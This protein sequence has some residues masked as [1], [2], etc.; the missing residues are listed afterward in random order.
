MADIFSKHD[1]K[2]L[3]SKRDIYM[4]GDSNM[5]AFYKDLICLVNKGTLIDDAKLRQKMEQSHMQDKLVRGSAITAGRDYVEEREYSRNNIYVKYHFITRCW[6]SSLENFVKKCADNVIR[7]DVVIVNSCL[8]DITRWGPRGV[9]QYRDNIVKLFQQFRKCLPK[10][11]LVIW[12][13]ALPVSLK[14]KPPFLVEQIDFLKHSLQFD[15]LEANV[16]AKNVL[17][18]NGYD[19]LDLYHYFRMQGL[20][21]KDDGVHWEPVAVRF[22]TNLVLTHVALSWNC[23]LPGRVTNVALKHCINMN[24]KPINQSSAIEIQSKA[25]ILPPASK[26]KEKP[27]KTEKKTREQ[28]LHK[29]P[30]HCNERNNNWQDT[31]WN[32]NVSTNF[33]NR[34]TVKWHSDENYNHTPR[35]NRYQ[36]VRQQENYRTVQYGYRSYAQ[37]NM[38]MMRP[39]Y[40]GSEWEYSHYQYENREDRYGGPIRRSRNRVPFW[41]RN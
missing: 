36:N 6:C 25:E 41:Q 12:T 37:N 5:R 17:T 18:T 33:D 38:N 34:R 31:N 24:N 4:F 13:T 8:W 39:N 28:R 14:C 32:N 22:I 15:I 2:Q 7:P 1:A 29:K 3:L 27:V 11:C 23:K 10:Q 16:L 40:N 35:R 19:V 30:Y 20:L 26:E 21:R 9:E